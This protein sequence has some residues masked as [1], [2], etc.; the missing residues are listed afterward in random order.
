MDNQKT[1]VIR[2]LLENEPD[3]QKRLALLAFDM[4]LAFNPYQAIKAWH[5]TSAVAEKL[6]NEPVVAAAH[7]L[8]VSAEELIGKAE[9]TPEEE[10]TIR[11]VVEEAAEH[12]RLAF[13]RSRYGKALSILDAIL[14]DAIP[15][16][17]DDAY[18]TQAM[19][20]LCFFALRPDIDPNAETSLTS[21]EVKELVSL[22]DGLCAYMAEHR[23][24]TDHD[25]DPVIAFLN[26][27]SPAAVERVKA[28]RIDSLSYP[29]D[30]VNSTIW[31]MLE[32]DTQGQ[33]M[34]KV[35]KVG[36]KKELSI[37][38][39]I[40]F[41]ELGAG[42]KISRKLTS[43]DKRVYVATAAL[44]NA[45]N[46]VFSLQQV[47]KAMGY[48]GT[49]GKADR[50]KISASLA[51]MN[52]AIVTIDNAQ[53]AAA[54]NYPVYTYTGSLLPMET[55]KKSIHGQ[56][57]EEAIHLF[58]EP[59]AMTF[60]RQRNQITTIPIALLR[61]PISKTENNL[62]IED[63]LL[64]RIAHMKKGNAS[65]RV[66]YKTICEKANIT[67]RKNRERLPGNVARYL[68]YYAKQGWIRSF[69]EEPDGVTIDLPAK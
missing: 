21:D 10:E 23:T 2:N 29:L 36:T 15:A 40:N 28:I 46:E 17:D 31:S 68:S 22:Y 56:V 67:E 27:R 13:L 11:E 6:A 55:V 12:H 58:R 48:T 61:S 19:A 44:Y 30:K 18:S 34:L 35:E 45:G 7:R 38:Y 5:T 65:R 37:L 49:P 62:Q 60:A 39:S 16:G 53:E 66:L 26:E 59:P 52:G 33:I 41:D 43:H 4:H 57:V 25:G 63:Y 69:T 24:D 42:A 32:R 9:R 1:E 51:K 64:E 3:M 47:Y 14:P 50:D 20:V 54:Y 8:G